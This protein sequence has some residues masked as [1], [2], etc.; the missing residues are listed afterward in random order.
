[1]SKDFRGKTRGLTASSKNTAFFF[2]KYGLYPIPFYHRLWEEKVIE[3]VQHTGLPNFHPYFARKKIVLLL[4][5]SIVLDGK[6]EKQICIY[7]GT[8]THT[9]SYR[10]WNL[11]VGSSNKT[12]WTFLFLSNNDIE[13]PCSPDR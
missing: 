11:N 3:R 12:V 10:S 6:L 13:A 9:L 8:H 4:K 2:N 5:A 7:Y 1:L